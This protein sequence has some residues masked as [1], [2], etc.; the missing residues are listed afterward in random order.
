MGVINDKRLLV[1]RQ[2]PPEFFEHAIVEA[3]GTL[4]G[5]TAACKRGMDLPS[6]GVGGSPPLLVSLATTREPL[7]LVNRPASRPSHDG[8]AGYLDQAADLCRRAGFRK[9]SFRGDT[10]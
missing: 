5:T 10:D 6:T 4:A 8:A 9:V 7:F 2:Q 1:W 3:D